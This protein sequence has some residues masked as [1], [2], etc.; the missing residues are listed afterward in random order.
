MPYTGILLSGAINKMIPYY[1]GRPYLIH[2]PPD[3]L[4]TIEMETILATRGAKPSVRSE[5]ANLILI[6]RLYLPILNYIPGLT[7]HKRSKG[8]GHFALFGSSLDYET[9]DD[10]VQPIFNFGLQLIFPYGG[11]ICFTS[12]VLLESPQII[13]PL[14]EYLVTPLNK[15]LTLATSVMESCTTGLNA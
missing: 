12:A 15:M 6:H 10:T 9:V 13:C 1:K 14:F 2:S 4:E 11:V 8:Q 3:C 5:D 7:D